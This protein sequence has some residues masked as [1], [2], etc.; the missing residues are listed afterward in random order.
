M[1]IFDFTKQERNNFIIGFFLLLVAFIM[2]YLS[3]YLANHATPLSKVTEQL[4]SSSVA[5]ETEP[6]IVAEDESGVNCYAIIHD[7]NNKLYLIKGN[8]KRI[9]SYKTHRILSGTA[10]KTEENIIEFTVKG[11]NLLADEEILSATNYTQFFGEYYLDID[12]PSFEKTFFQT[13]SI[14]STLLSIFF[15]AVSI[16]SK[17]NTNNTIN[18]EEYIKIEKELNDYKQPV[19]NI[20]ITKSYILIYNFGLSFIKKS[21][22]K[23][24][25]VIKTKLG[26]N[27]KYNTKQDEDY[28][29]INIGNNSKKTENTLNELKPSKK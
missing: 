7:E 10:F 18:S 20:I 11:Y 28:K 1:N 9:Q 2:M 26:Y 5:S 29:K 27:L 25:E 8:K 12:S 22:L 23:E 16:I 19:K 21:D 3:S 4:Q 17:I 6:F 24:V 13:A 15:I 14:I